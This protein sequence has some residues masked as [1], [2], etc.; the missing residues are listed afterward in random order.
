MH[1]KETGQGA[2]PPPDSVDPDVYDSWVVPATS[3]TKDKHYILSGS[4]E[5][6]FWYLVPRSVIHSK[7]PILAGAE[8]VRIE[9][10]INARRWATLEW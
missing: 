8:I 9:E 3:T 5:S 7:D 2:L 6:P 10:L 1:D 4:A